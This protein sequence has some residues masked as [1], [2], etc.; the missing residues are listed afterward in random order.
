VKER[1]SL[2]MHDYID[3]PK[4]KLEYNKELFTEI[5][6]KYGFVNRVL[7]LG[8]DAVWKD[9]LVGGLPDVDRPECLDMAC[10]TGDITFRLA[11]KYPHG[12][13]LGLDVTDAM[14]SRARQRNNYSN[15]QFTIKDMC[16]TQLDESSFDIIT[17]GYAL[18][19]APDI[20]A[21]LDE[22]SRLMKP[23]GTGAFLDFSKPAG[24]FLQKLENALLKPWCALWGWLLLRNTEVCTYIVESLRQYPNHQQ[25]K[26]YLTESG[27]ENIRSKRYYCGITESI[28]FEKQKGK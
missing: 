12:N 19:N 25:L 7:S 11:Q 10:G 28:L 26:Q 9:R 16:K 3:S 21:A 6:G 22:I 14:I 24:V 15:V 2:K 23:G 20:K 13:I 18:R 17:G 1:F 5:A 27:F 4:G 8:R